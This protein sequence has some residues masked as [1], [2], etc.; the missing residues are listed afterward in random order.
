MKQHNKTDKIIREKMEQYSS[1]TPM[2]LF[3]GIMNAIDIEAAPAPKQKPWRKGGWLLSILALILVGGGTWYAF[4]GNKK[5]VTDNERLTVNFDRENQNTVSEKIIDEESIIST[6]KYNSEA[7]N[8]NT[9]NSFSNIISK[10][11]RNQNTTIESTSNNN[12]A[13]NSNNKSN[14]SIQNQAKNNNIFTNSIFSKTIQNRE[15][16][17]AVINN[18]SS[19]N[20]R[21]DKLMEKGG[22]IENTVSTSLNQ[23]DNSITNSNSSTTQNPNGTSVKNESGLNKNNKTIA[24]RSPIKES[25]LFLP[26]L[27]STQRLSRN[28]EPYKINVDPLCGLKPDGSK[29]RFT[30][31]VDAFFSL[32]YAAQILEYK[33]ENFKANAEKRTQT[34]SPYYSFNT[35]VR[36]NFLTEFDWALRT[37]IVYTQINDIL[38]TTH[39]EEVIAF[40]ANGDT[41]SVTSG[42]RDVNIRNRYKMVDIPILIG[43][44]VAMKR[45]TLNVNGGVFVNISSKQS[46]AFFSP[47]NDKV[48]YFTQG[49]SDNYDIFKNRIGFSTFLGLGFNFDLGKKFKNTQLIIEP[50]T[51]FYPK[52]FTLKNYTVLNQKYLSAG[53]MIGLRK[54]L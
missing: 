33:A 45:F 24:N 21:K 9:E 31:S 11:S 5:A 7:Q 12:T 19:F 1:D 41:L 40:D 48:V 4:S 27:K 16:N 30:T 43:Y 46:G 53:V 15:S 2:H 35:G 22:N 10:A 18:N 23:S 20:L 8:T 36:V 25:V 6:E 54:D 42:T 34:E 29:I 47:L 39:R 3:D 50:H 13:I 44:E 37:G 38:K 14:T 17:N 26:D 52:S 49:H 32:D 51:R 28:T